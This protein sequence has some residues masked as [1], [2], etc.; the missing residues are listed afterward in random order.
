MKKYLIKRLLIMIPMLLGITLL[1][2]MLMNLAPGDPVMMFVDTEKGVPTA[3]EL[4]RVSGIA[5]A[6]PASSYPLYLMAEESGH[7]EF[8]VFDVLPAASSFRDTSPD[9]NDNPAFILVYGDFGVDRYVCWDYL[10]AEP[11]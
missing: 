6:G 7:R 5:W 10:C 4:A 3:A 2:F 11:I 1:S 8:G 9:W